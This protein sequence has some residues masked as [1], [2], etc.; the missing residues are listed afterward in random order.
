MAARAD[1]PARRSR[2]AAREAD[3][4]GIVYIE[5]EGFESLLEQAR[6]AERFVYEDDDALAI[7]G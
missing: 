3:F 6:I 7:V 4:G 1:S 2:P 5:K